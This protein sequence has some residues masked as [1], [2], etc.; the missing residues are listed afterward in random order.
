M[1]V[2]WPKYK[3]HK[4]V[5][6]LKILGI[7]LP[8]NQA[9]DAELRFEE[10]YAPILMNREWLDKHNPEVGGYIVLYEDGYQSYSPAKPF[11]DGYTLI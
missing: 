3:C 8:Q 2:D 11:E 7:S 5:R 10:P 6:A 1:P 9:G 4:E